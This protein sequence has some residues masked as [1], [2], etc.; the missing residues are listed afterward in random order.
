MKIEELSI[1]GLYSQ[2][3]NK[4]TAALLQVLG[5]GGSSL[6]HWI[7]SEIGGNLVFNTIESIESQPA[8][9][10][11]G[12][13]PDGKIICDN[14]TLFIES[15]LGCGISEHQLKCHGKLL[16][17]KQNYLVYVTN[18]PDRPKE[19]P[20]DVL[21]TNWEAV[22]AR[23]EAYQ[24]ADKVLEFLISQF[25]KLELFELFKY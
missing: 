11:T 8:Q 13:I 12:S 18:N 14:F 5:F 10:G 2:K 4:V 21:W 20:V 25:C 1:F 22:V 24:T 17:D 9:E 3:E 16:K 7:L 6:L 19:L 23:F 15:K